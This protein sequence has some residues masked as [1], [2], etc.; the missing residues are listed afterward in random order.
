MSAG[1]QPLNDERVDLRPGRDSY[2]QDAE[3]TDQPALHRG[4]HRRHLE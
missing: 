2:G 4:G 1:F 3:R